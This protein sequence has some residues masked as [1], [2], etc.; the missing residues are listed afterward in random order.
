M[1]ILP[2]LAILEQLLV[3]E[4]RNSERPRRELRRQETLWGKASLSTEQDR[5]D[6]GIMNFTSA[7]SA[8]RKNAPSDFILH[9][10]ILYVRKVRERL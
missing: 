2:V 1:A 5:G 8:N 10:R 9:I 6:P 3:V 4:I 7:H